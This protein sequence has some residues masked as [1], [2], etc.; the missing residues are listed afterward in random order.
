MAPHTTTLENK[1]L[2]SELGSKKAGLIVSY[3][4]RADGDSGEPVKA[5]DR[6][7][8]TSDSGELIEND[9]LPRVS[10]V[11]L[12]TVRGLFNNIQYNLGLTIDNIQFL[13]IVQE[14]TMVEGESEAII[15]YMKDGAVLN[16]NSEDIALNAGIINVNEERIQEAINGLKLKG[17]SERIFL[18]YQKPVEKTGV[19]A[20]NILARPMSRVVGDRVEYEYE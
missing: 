10:A 18:V 9:K 15:H 17:I 12:G 16:V 13:T 6:G 7:E 3:R 14:R 20:D 11:L 5:A 19:F 4:R 1:E 2:V 8:L